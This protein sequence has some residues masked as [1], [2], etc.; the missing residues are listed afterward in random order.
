VEA[1]PSDPE[2]LE[3]LRHVLS[4]FGEPV[5]ASREGAAVRLAGGDAQLADVVRALDAEDIHVAHL[6]LHSPTLD[7][8]FLAKTGHA[9]E[10]A[11]DEPE[12]EPAAA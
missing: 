10:G 9:L 8:V 2:D 11:G 12:P 1:I 7:D 5:G 3:R 4:R 6:E